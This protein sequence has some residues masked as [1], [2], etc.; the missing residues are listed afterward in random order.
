MYFNPICTASRFN[1]FYTV[2]CVWSL[3]TETFLYDLL[4]ILKRLLH[5]FF[6]ITLQWDISSTFSKND[7]LENPEE[8]F[9][10]A[11]LYT[12]YCL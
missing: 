7:Y 2:I 8:M 12:K 10:I 5:S 6:E 11:V 9:P 4:G 1:D 3:T